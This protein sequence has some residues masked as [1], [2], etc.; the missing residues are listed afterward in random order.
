MC[1][2]DSRMQDPAT[3]GDSPY[4]RT[5]RLRREGVVTAKVTVPYDTARRRE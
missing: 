1:E 2:V 3:Q 4:L 5:A